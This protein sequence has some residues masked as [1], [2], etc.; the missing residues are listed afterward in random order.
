MAIE[1]PESIK[2]FLEEMLFEILDVYRLNGT[3]FSS[4]LVGIDGD[5]CLFINSHD[6][7]FIEYIPD[8]KNAHSRVRKGWS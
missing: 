4:K 7:R 1:E 2:S 8:I 6:D 5:R 3:H